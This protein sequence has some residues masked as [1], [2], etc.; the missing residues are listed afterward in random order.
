MNRPAVIV[1]KQIGNLLAELAVVES[2]H[3]N[4]RLTPV[5]NG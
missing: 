3:A 4:V 2:E 1:L 5:S